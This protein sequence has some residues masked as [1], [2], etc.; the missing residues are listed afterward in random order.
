VSREQRPDPRVTVL[1]YLCWYAV[2]GIR[3]ATVLLALLIVQGITLILAG[4][5][6]RRNLQILAT[7]CV[8]GAILSGVARTVGNESF[9]DLVRMWYTWG[10]IVLATL[11]VS[12]SV[13]PSGLFQALR[14]YRIPSAIAFSL[15]IAIK[16]LP[17]VIRECQ[18]VIVAMRARGRTGGVG[19]KRIIEWPRFAFDV[20][21]PTLVQVLKRAEQMWFTVELRGSRDVVL[22]LDDGMY[23]VGRTVVATVLLP[24][25]LVAALLS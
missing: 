20:M 15:W 22:L 14:F 5:L 8:V 6:H 13:A 16:V 19:V 2:I 10:I 9:S 1:C 4:G 24:M 18:C 12:S 7:C 23:S 17:L 3:S 11:S 25:P 21:I